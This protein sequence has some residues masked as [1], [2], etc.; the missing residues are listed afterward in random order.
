MHKKKAIIIGAGPAGLTAAYELATRTKIKPIIF[1][2]DNNIGGISKTMEYKGYKFDMGPH[3]FF[4][5]SDRVT[6]LWLNMLSLQGIPAK[7]DKTNILNLEKGDKVLLY[8]KRLTR[9]F[10]LRNFFDYPIT[11]S[12]RTIFNLGIIRIAKIFISYL[13]IKLFPIKNEISLEDFFINRFGKELYSTFFKD[14]TEKVWGMSCDKIPCKWGIQRIKGL[15]ISNVM[16]HAIKKILFIANHSK[17]NETSLVESFMYPKFGA[18]QMYSE[19]AGEVKKKGGE[20][21]LNH[22]IINIILKQNRITK[23]KVKDLI[24]GEVKIIRGDYFFSTMPIKDLI[25]S[26]NDSKVPKNVK[27]IANGLVYRDY[28]IVGIL[29]KDIILKDK[30]NNIISD[31]WIYIQES[32]VKIGRLVFFNNFSIHLLKNDNNIW[33]GAE[34]FCNEGDELWNKSN[35]DIAKFAIDEL[36]KI[37]II[38]KEDVIDYTVAKVPKAYPAYFGT[39]TKLN[40]IRKFVD[41]FENLFLIGRNGLHQYNNMDHSMLTAMIAVDNIINNHKSKENIWAVNTEKI[42]H[43]QK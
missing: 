23:L 7:N 37:D 9:I 42:Y 41:N 31:N 28:L 16:F 26:I 32:D 43:E 10:F 14:Y 2:M 25:D 27:N 33:L 8:K 40:N 12:F 21:Y 5:K 3:R 38:H 34:Y 36:E 29:V 4:S 35:T 13:K 15:S 20:I 18:G 39:Y 30:A 11:L 1:E 17:R 19:I 22:K 6:K 24:T